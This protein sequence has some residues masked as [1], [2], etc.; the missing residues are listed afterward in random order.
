MKCDNAKIKTLSRS[1]SFHP[2]VKHKKMRNEEQDKTGQNRTKQDKTGQFE[3][4]KKQTLKTPSTSFE[5]KE[6]T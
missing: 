2:L 6:V 3:K 1:S 5:S 4:L